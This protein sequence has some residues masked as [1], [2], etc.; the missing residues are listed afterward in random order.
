MMRMK[1]EA[2]SDNSGAEEYSESTTH[3]ADWS[4][5][6][7]A[8]L[9]FSATWNPVGFLAVL[10]D[11]RKWMSALP[12]K[13]NPF[14]PWSTRDPPVECTEDDCPADRC[15]DPA[16]ECDGRY[17]WGY[18]GHYVTGDDVKYAVPT[19]ESA[20]RVFIFTKNDPFVFVDM[21]DVRCPE[22]GAVHPAAIAFLAVLGPTWVEVS[23][24]GTGLHSVYRGELPEGLKQ[25]TLQIDDGVWGSITP[26]VDETEEDVL[27]AIELYDTARKV[28]VLTGAT[29]PGSPGEVNECDA[30]A[31]RNILDAHGEFPDENAGRDGDTGPTVPD[32]NT[33][34][35]SER[36]GDTGI[37]DDMEDVFDAI[38]DLDARDVADQTIVREWLDS[39][40]ASERAFVP[41]WAPSG[42][43]G[44][45]NYC[46]EEWWTDTGHRDGWGGPLIMAAIDL[47]IISDNG[48]SPGDVKGRE[49]VQ[50]CVEHLRNHGF[51]IPEYVPGGDSSTLYMDVIG[52]YA[53][54]DAD[55]YGDPN[56]C[57]EACLRARED[58]AVPD[59]ADV[60]VLALHPVIDGVLGVSA[61]SHAVDDGTRSLARDVVD[62]LTINSARERGLI[63]S[64]DAGNGGEDE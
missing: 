56:D 55:P 26:G 62:E 58:G 23:S 49:D 8:D 1:N 6:Y 5:S 34:G 15:D 50:R 36:S 19:S 30:A 29:V 48:A 51:D 4:G 43:D 40:N 17:K 13:K 45:A 46:T 22:T 2:T 57:L 7:V 18:E 59:G 42:Y 47:K 35:D 61:D 64:A 32:L 16:C 3:Q 28:G 21:D 33:G 27:P 25:P 10:N 38:N 44:A 37:T 41:T 63:P 60:P 31:L 9:N 11:R 54:G 14:A 52:T 12:G 20:Y 53:P 24:S 39:R